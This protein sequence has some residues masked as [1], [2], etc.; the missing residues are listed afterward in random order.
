MDTIVEIS[1]VSHDREVTLRSIG[2]AFKEIERIEKLFN[3][4]DDKSEVSRVNA[5]AGIEEVSISPELFGLIERS[6]HYSAVSGG[7]F[8]ITVMP[9]VDVWR[10][11]KERGSIPDEDEIN[12]IVGHVGYKK[13][14]LD[15]DSLTIRFL[16]K[17]T[18]ID[19]GGIAKGYAV[20]RAKDVL[21]SGG[22]KD[23]LINIGGNIFAMGNAPGRDGW[24]IG[25]QDPRHKRDIAYRL[26]LKNKAVSTSGD[27]ERF[28]ILGAKRFSH[29]I[30]P[31]TGKPAEGV[32][33]TTIVSDSAEQADALSTAVFV[34]GVKKGTDLI[35]SFE[36]T[37]VF[38]FN[39]DSKLISFPFL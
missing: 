34:L 12:T 30:N 33:S 36:G 1:C 20:D 39:E 38:I 16:D 13:I 2:E 14:L 7:S 25:I 17:D 32:I 31:L 5:V 10:V 19:L 35:R 21:V 6:I 27:Y 29:I 8:D 28:F 3:R 24:H 23:A 26:K 11:A 15:S 4:Y 22:I 18:K 9:L 37:E